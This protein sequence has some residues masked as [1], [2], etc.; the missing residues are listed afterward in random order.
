[1]SSI[2]SLSCHGHITRK[3]KKEPRLTVSEP[4]PRRLAARTF[5][6]TDVARVARN[7][8]SLSLALSLASKTSMISKSQRINRDNFENIMKKGG[9]I[10]S[11]LFSLK[12]LKNPINTT[13]FSVVVSKKVAKTAVLRNKIRRRG[14]S[15][16]GK[17]AKSL[18]NPYFIILFVKRGAEKATFTETEVQILEMLKKA[19]IL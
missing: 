6:G 18:N 1:M 16:F 10:N 8:R 14:Y 4:A 11:S 17:V 12:F 5:S 2:Y 7:C 3:R 19:K 13:H 15:V 9:M